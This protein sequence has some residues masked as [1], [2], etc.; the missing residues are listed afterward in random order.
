M[1]DTRDPR[2]YK[3]TV[4]IPD[5]SQLTEEEREDY[6]RYPVRL[7][8]PSW[9]DAVAHRQDLDRSAKGGTER[10]PKRRPSEPPAPLPDDAVVDQRS[11]P[12]PRDLYLRL[13][14]AGAFPTNKIGKRITARWGDVKAAFAVR[15]EQEASPDESDRSDSREE[16]AEPDDGLDEL[17]QD[18]GLV[19]KAT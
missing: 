3:F 12:V 17:R 15:A 13:H 4:E 7:L 14:R 11:A 5:F 9:E 8:Y 10:Q 18:L 6:T 16:P 1:S 2:D 19:K